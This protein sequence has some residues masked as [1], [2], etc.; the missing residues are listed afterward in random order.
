MCRLFT[1]LVPR[2]LPGDGHGQSY[3]GGNFWLSGPYAGSV[4]SRKE[5]L[6]VPLKF[7][8]GDFFGKIY[9]KY[10]LKKAIQFF[11]NFSCAPIGRTTGDPIPGREGITLRIF[12]CKQAWLKIFLII[13]FLVIFINFSKVFLIW[14]TFCS[15]PSI[16]PCP[17]SWSTTFWPP[18][19]RPC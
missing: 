16:C 12:F 11:K 14:P 6:K 8:E 18:W 7:F 10:Q 3:T 2:V 17:G 9:E 4:S 5:K 1:T 15:S 13:L 19:T